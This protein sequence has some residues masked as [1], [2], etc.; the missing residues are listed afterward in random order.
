MALRDHLVAWPAWRRA[1]TVLVYLPFG[2]EIDPCPPLAARRAFITRTDARAA[3]LS[4][5]DVRSATD[6]HPLGFLQPPL[7]TPE[8]DVDE[9]ELALVPGLVFDER[10]VRLGYG[11]ALYDGLLPRLP[12][13]AP[14]VG[15]TLDALVVP[16]LPCEAHDV[17]VTHLL[18]PSGLRAV[19][20]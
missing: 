17:P 6:R 14:R 7:G 8:A 15:V 12:A 13:S 3:R 16:A 1:A 20:G 18:T 19:A 9:I 5:H 10:G 4:V 2:D 11:R